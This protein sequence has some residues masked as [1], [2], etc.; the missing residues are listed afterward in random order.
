MSNQ[1]IYEL[2]QEDLAEFRR[3]LERL[4]EL[5]AESEEENDG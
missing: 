2:I 1:E 3:L 5:L 4:R